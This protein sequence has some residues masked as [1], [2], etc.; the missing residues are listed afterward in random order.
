MS[1][2]LRSQVVSEGGAVQGVKLGGDSL[3]YGGAA[4]C[5]ED[6]AGGL[7][8]HVGIFDVGL[9]THAETGEDAQRSGL[10]VPRPDHCRVM[11]GRPCL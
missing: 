2:G 3:G 6:C 11:A 10:S 8:E 5:S 7:L 9:S 4:R 1:R